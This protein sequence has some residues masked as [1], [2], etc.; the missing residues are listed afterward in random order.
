MHD[1]ATANQTSLM[2]CLSRAKFTL[3]FSNAVS[4]ASYTHPTREYLTGRWTDSLASGAVVAGIAPKFDGSAE[5]L[6]KGATLEL[7]TTDRVQGIE[8]LRTAVSSW[9]PQVARDNYRRALEGLDWRWRFQEL[10]MALDVEPEPLS[11][12]L[13]S[14]AEAL[15][16]GA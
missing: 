7:G 3:A 16:D 1:D 11:V 8:Q 9:N 4:P 13:D 12:E 5:L 14:L 15:K 2:R 6:W 10:A